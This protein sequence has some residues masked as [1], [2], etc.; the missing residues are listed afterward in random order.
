MKTLALLMIASWPA[1]WSSAQQNQIPEV[2]L[3]DL[4]GKIISSSEIITPGALTLVVFWKSTD[5]KC[6]ENLETMADAWDET[7]RQKGVKMVAVCVDCSGSWGTIKPII[8]GNDWDFEAYIDVNGDLKR[9]MCVGEGPCSMLFNAEQNLVCRYN[10]ACSGSEEF[11]CG[12]IL[13]HLDNI[14]TA[15]NFEDDK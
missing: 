10:S 9:A 2:D 7:L 13:D 12:N 1:F 4:N 15:A 14:V 8:N 6:C 5:G 11:I 3:R